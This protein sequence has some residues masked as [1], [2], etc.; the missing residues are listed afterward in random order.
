M[1]TIMTFPGKIGDALL[2][3]PVAAWWAE[4]N[5]KPITL[6]LDENSLGKLKTLFEAQPCVE[7]VVMKPG[8]VN[9]S[10]GGQPWHFDVRTEDIVGHTL[11][12]LG[13]RR[14]PERQITLQTA[15]DVGFHVDT[16]ALTQKPWLLV[17]PH[18]PR[19]RLILHGT[20]QSHMTGVPHFWRWLRDTR[21]DLENRFDEI[22]FVGSPD[23]RTR[24]QELYPDY[25]TYDDAGDFLEL[26]RFVAGSRMVAGTGS[27]VVALAGVLRVAAVRVHDPIGEAPKH[28]WSNLGENQINETEVALRK[29]WKPFADRWAPIE[30][31]AEVVA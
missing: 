13:F 29:A 27:S 31:I 30:S 9:Y 17:E 21:H 19:N 12:H 15:M 7:Q 1:A 14:F 23:E 6:W 3:F 8:I 4:K 5:S 25:K 2:Q 16:G 10:C 18:E 28:I 24:A 20:F 11:Y 26:A 22:Y